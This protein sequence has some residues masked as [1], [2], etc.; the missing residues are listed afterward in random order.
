MLFQNESLLYHLFFIVLQFSIKINIT[1]KRY[2][3]IG[4]NYETNY[5]KKWQS[6][7]NL[8]PN[9]CKA[10]KHFQIVISILT[11]LKNDIVVTFKWRKHSLTTI[12]KSKM[13]RITLTLPNQFQKF[14]QYYDSD[15][16]CLL[17][18]FLFQNRCLLEG[19]KREKMSSFCITIH[20]YFIDVVWTYRNKT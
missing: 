7:R 19:C 14:F 9:E 5:K 3:F 20:T 18:Y 12:L 16:L 15:N 13:I 10:K 4:N 17:D 8:L 1:K 11:N 6:F 2:L